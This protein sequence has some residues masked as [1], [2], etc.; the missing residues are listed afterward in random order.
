MVTNLA[1]LNTIIDNASGVYAIA[2]MVFLIEPKAKS[3]SHCLRVIVVSRVIVSLGSLKI[4]KGEYFCEA[5]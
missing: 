1:V 5:L 2:S 4:I 3:I